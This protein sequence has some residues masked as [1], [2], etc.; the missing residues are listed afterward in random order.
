MNQAIESE[1]EI[2]VC[3]ECLEEIGFADTGE[4]KLT[5]CENCHLVEGGTKYIPLSEYEAR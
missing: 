2:C 1:E 5:Y 4:D 3:V